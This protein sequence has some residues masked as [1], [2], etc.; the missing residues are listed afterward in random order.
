MAI[1]T[2]A[3][4]P[5]RPRVVVPLAEQETILRWAADEEHVSVFTAHPATRRRIERRGYEPVRVSTQHGRPVGWFY[6]VP[7]PE[8]AWRVGARRRPGRVLTEAQRAAAVARLAQGR[9]TRA[10]GA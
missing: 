3:Q 10:S 8:L 6:R 4:T 5:P 7:L 9:L 2:L 1:E